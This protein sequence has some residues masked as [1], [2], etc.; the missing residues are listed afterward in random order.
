MEDLM[1]AKKDEARQLNLRLSAEEYA[2]LE[3][4]AELLP[5][6][7]IAKAAL[8]VGLAEI[9]KRPSILLE[10]VPTKRSR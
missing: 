8:L 3:K 7:A 6:T 4:L 10:G 2:R 1:A 9:E 5:I